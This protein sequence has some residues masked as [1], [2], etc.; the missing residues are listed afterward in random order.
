MKYPRPL[1]KK[2]RDEIE[3]E[4]KKMEM[5]NLFQ[6]MHGMKEDSDEE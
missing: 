6:K 4:K 1:S 2:E 5:E 3:D